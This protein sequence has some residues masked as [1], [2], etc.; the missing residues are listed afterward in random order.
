MS[1]ALELLHPKLKGVL[2]RL[3]YS[4]LLPVQEKAIPVILSKNHTLVIA[5][6]G[7][8]KTEERALPER[9]RYSSDSR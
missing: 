7:S 2:P 6:T 4:R 3:G 5:P 8:G 9:W 1:G